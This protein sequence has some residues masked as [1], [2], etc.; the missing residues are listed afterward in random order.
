MQATTPERPSSIRTV[1]ALV[2]G[3]LTWVPMYFVGVAVVA[4]V[5]GDDL[6]R[7]NGALLALGVAA[8]LVSATVTVLALPRATRR[9]LLP[10]TVLGAVPSAIVTAGIVWSTTVEAK[11]RGYDVGGDLAS[12][13]GFVVVVA[14]VTA[15]LVA[16]LRERSSRAA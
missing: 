14:A 8:P 7:L 11:E 15:A 12:G 5:V 16:W 6:T 1:L 4:A 9:R 13:L 3:A 2:A 10:A